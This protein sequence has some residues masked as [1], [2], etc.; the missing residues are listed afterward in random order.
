MKKNLTLPHDIGLNQTQAHTLLILREQGA[1]PMQL[2]GRLSG[3]VKGSL[4][5]VVDGLVESGFVER[6]RAPD[7]RRTV[8][9]S[10]TA[11][12]L[13]LTKRLDENLIEHTESIMSIFTEEQRRDIFKALEIIQNSLDRMEEREKD[14][15][16]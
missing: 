4:T 12:G 13:E 5:Q 10:I 7:D 15:A 2:L 8:L 3:I 16:E 14:A 6:M 9:V 11:H 1:V